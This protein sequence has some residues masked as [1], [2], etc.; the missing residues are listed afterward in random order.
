MLRNW[1]VAIYP[2]GGGNTRGAGKRGGGGNKEGEGSSEKKVNT[3]LE[4][5]WLCPHHKRGKE[6][7]IGVDQ[8][9]HKRVQARY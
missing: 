7:F 8:G 9:G 2:G 4:K 6:K 3:E 5:R 1:G